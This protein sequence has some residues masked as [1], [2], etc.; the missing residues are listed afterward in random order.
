MKS[1][2]TDRG[3]LESA[4]GVGR[5]LGNEPFSLEGDLEADGRAGN[6]CGGYRFFFKL[7]Y[8]RST[9]PMEFVTSP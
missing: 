1:G 7:V 2:P 9:N 4:S 6:R 5:Q 3:G 8:T